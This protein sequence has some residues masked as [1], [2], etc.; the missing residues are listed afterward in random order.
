MKKILF[1]MT[2][3][4]MALSLTACSDD[5]A[6]KMM[7]GVLNTVM[8]MGVVFVVLIFMAFLISRFKYINQIEKNFKEKKRKQAEAEAAARL[9]ADEAK[10]AAA[11]APAPAPAPVVEETLEEVYEEADDLE[12]VAVISAALCAALGT[13]SD[14]LIV[15]SIKRRNG[16]RW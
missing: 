14:K 12:L 9:K 4:W 3:T 10:K 7:N 8:C 5:L 2:T 1:L 15:R 6:A 16:K 13:T 11:P